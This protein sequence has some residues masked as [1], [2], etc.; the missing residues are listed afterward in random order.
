VCLACSPIEQTLGGAL[1]LQMDCDRWVSS[2]DGHPLKHCTPPA[3]ASTGAGAGST[4]PKRVCLSCKLHG[5]AEVRARLEPAAEDGGGAA[6]E[7]AAATASEPMDTPIYGAGDGT[8]SSSSSS[9]IA[10]RPEE[11]GR[12]GADDG[13]AQLGG[14][15]ARSD[16]AAMAASDSI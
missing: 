1:P 10:A 13:G 16:R 4:K 9:S 3:T 6:A 12:R 2:T 5:P 7:P 14:A 11:A 8:S 15:V